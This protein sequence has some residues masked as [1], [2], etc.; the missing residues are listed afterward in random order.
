MSWPPPLLKLSLSLSVCVCVAMITQA[1]S[2][3]PVMSGASPAS[4]HSTMKSAYKNSALP[5]SY[6]QKVALADSICS[7][8]LFLCDCWFLPLGYG[9]CS[10]HSWIPLWL[11]HSCLPPVSTLNFESSSLPVCNI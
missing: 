2:G 9:L 4:S 6:C 3:V 5:H 8:F 10:D 11:H 1:E 7:V